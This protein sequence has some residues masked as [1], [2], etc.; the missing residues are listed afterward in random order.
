[1]ERRGVSAQ[2]R[3]GDPEAVRAVYRE[4]GRLVFSVAYRILGNRGLAEEA[5][6]QTFLKAWRAAGSFDLNR[7]L[8]PWLASI[9]RRAAIDVSRREAVRMADPLDSVSPADP[10]LISRPESAEAI[11]DVWAV[12]QAV[13]ELPD[14]EQEIVRMQHFEGLTHGEIAERLKLPVGTVKSRSFRAHKRLAAVLGHLR[15]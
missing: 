15:E 14:D 11:Y 7:S 10:A 12:R 4:Y 9:A 2:F 8:G 1:M 13:A 5:T 6:Q 3:E